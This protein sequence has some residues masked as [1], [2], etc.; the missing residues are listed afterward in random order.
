MELNTYQSRAAGTRQALRRGDLAEAVPFIGLAS[1]TGELLN[2][3]KKLIR[4]GSAHE[5]FR[6]RLTEE[7]GDPLWYLADAASRFE[8]ALEDV[9]SANLAKTRERW[10]GHDAHREPAVRGDPRVF[11]AAYPAN[12][13]IPRR[14]KARF[15]QRTQGERLHVR[16]LVGDAQMG[17]ELDD[18][19]HFTDGYRFHDVFHLACAAVLGWSPVTWRSLKCKRRSLDAIDRNEDG[20]RATVTEEG[21]SALVFSYAVDHARMDGVGWLDYGLLK[22]IK[23]MTAKFDVNV[24][25]TVEWARAIMLA[26]RMWRL[27]EAHAGGDVVVD[28]DR[29]NLTFTPPHPGREP[30]VA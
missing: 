30:E 19:T 4:D 13:Q 3:Y 5:R 23:A 7:L 25:S 16:V 9:A 20:G 24:C 2:E 28:L 26:Y 29:R 10:D 8:I 14:F 11:D 21:V 12:E 17:Q 27:D 15:Y 1:E 6:E 22:A 18:N